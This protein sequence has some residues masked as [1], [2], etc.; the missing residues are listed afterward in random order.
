[1]KTDFSKCLLVTL[2]PVLLFFLLYRV[3]LYAY[4]L[5]Y[6]YWSSEGWGY[7]VLLI[8]MAARTIRLF[9]LGN[10]TNYLQLLQWRALGY[11]AG[12]III[13]PVIFLPVVGFVLVLQLNFQL[14]LLGYC[15]VVVTT[16]ALLEH[17]WT[18]HQIC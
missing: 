2:L 14:L 8:A 10:T 15:C 13:A 16:K 5:Q 1:M 17:L 18:K 6:T 9:A 12:S 7:L 4:L 3:F 11:D